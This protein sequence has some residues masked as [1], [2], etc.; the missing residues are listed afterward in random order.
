MV[1]EERVVNIDV[2]GRKRFLVVVV[3]FI[4]GREFSEF[5]CDC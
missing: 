4:V 3:V 1:I 5:D 2:V